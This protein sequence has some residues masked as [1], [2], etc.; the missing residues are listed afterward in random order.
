MILGKGR[1]E[2]RDRGDAL[3]SSVGKLKGK[4]VKVVKRAVKLRIAVLVGKLRLLSANGVELADKI[5]LT[6]YNS[7]QEGE[8][9]GQNNRYGY[10]R[11]KVSAFFLNSFH[12]STPFLP[13]LVR[14][15]PLSHRVCASAPRLSWLQSRG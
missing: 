13:F 10:C 4:S 15:H 5:F 12:I 8:Q 2:G 7:N 3:A 6:I 14:G 9:N 11:N 1:A